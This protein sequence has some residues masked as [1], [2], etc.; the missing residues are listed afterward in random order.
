MDMK[1][2]GGGREDSYKPYGVA[3]KKENASG[4]SNMAGFNKIGEGRGGETKLPEIN[5]KQ[6][7][8]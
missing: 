4:Q 7:I 3:A 5:K 6:S 1:Q 8:E 2:G